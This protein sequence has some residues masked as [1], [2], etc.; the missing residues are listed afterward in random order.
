MMVSGA[1][2]IQRTSREGHGPVGSL[3]TSD[4]VPRLVHSRLVEEL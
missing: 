2:L 4:F 3:G 1:D